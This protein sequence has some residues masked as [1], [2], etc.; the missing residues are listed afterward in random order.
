MLA[1][2]AFIGT[3]SLQPPLAARGGSCLATGA[4]SVSRMVLEL[5]VPFH[6]TRQKALHMGQVRVFYLFPFNTLVGRAT[7]G[8][9]SISIT[10]FDLWHY[11]FKVLYN[12][13]CFRNIYAPLG[14]EFKISTYMYKALWIQNFVQGRTKHNQRRVKDYIIMIK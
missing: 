11:E 1:V 14:A 9:E 10:L 7:I 5:P 12:M 4:F 13:K 6:P 3:F 8:F 2:W